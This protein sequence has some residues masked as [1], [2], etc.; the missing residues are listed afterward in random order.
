[1]GTTYIAG[2][3]WGVVSENEQERLNEVLRTL[4][5]ELPEDHPYRDYYTFD[6]ERPD[7][8]GFFE[9]F[10]PDTIAS[11]YIGNLQWDGAEIGIFAKSATKRAYDFDTV[12]FEELPDIPDEERAV[13]EKYA[14]L[15]GTSPKWHV[16]M[17]AG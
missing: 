10:H 1:M 14:N 12:S 7:A 5:E 6:L 2:V 9:F 16:F 4:Q 8:T 15:L 17:Y 13:V 11:E 3:G